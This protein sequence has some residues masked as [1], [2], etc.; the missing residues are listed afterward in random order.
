MCEYDKS[1]IY[2]L[3]GFTYQIKVFAVQL[4]RLHK[5]DQL[6]FETLDDVTLPI[7]T[8]GIDEYC[9]KTVSYCSVESNYKAIQV[10][11]TKVTNAVAKQIIKN[12]MNIELKDN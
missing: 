5:G 6:E 9:D 1:G 3:G 11:K 4:I 7:K 12:L 8:T 10:K 2:S